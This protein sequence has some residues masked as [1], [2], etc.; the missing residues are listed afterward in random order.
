MQAMRRG[1]RPW[2]QRGCERSCACRGSCFPLDCLDHR[3]EDALYGHQLTAVLETKAVDDLHRFAFGIAPT[4]GVALLQLLWFAV[5]CLIDFDD[6]PRDPFVLLLLSTE[7]RA[8][9]RRA[10]LK[11]RRVQCMCNAACVA[12]VRKLDALEVTTDDISRFV[13]YEPVAHCGSPTSSQKR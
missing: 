8:K 6:Q 10:L 11:R 2:R 9:L 13:V 4:Q 3:D 7:R 1:S 12:F 5:T